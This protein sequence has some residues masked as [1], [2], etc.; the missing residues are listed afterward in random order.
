MN[1]DGYTAF[2]NYWLPY[3]EYRGIG[4]HDATWRSSFGGSIY[5]GNGSHGCVNTPYS[6]MQ[7]LYEMVEAGTPVVVY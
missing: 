6:V 7:S 2:V 1:G 4:I 3:Y 5:Q